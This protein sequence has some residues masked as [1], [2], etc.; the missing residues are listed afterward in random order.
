MACALHDLLGRG[1]LFASH[2][3]V[4]TV[5]PVDAVP[6]VAFVFALADFELV[7]QPMQITA[8]YAKSSRALRFAP[9]T[10]AQRA[11]QTGGA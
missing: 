5:R 6:V 9:A 2:D 1:K 4:R 8:C 3:A 7:D 10:F 11:N